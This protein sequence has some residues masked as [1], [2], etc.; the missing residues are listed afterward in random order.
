V[1]EEL[2]D[3]GQFGGDARRHFR[4]RTGKC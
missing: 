3:D 4:E 1:V 2:L